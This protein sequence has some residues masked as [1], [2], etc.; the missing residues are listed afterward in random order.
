MQ[1]IT[2]TAALLKQQYVSQDALLGLLAAEQSRVQTEAST[3]LGRSTDELVKDTVL[4][5]GDKLRE[6]HFVAEA[7]LTT[8]VINN[9]ADFLVSQHVITAVNEAR[10]R[11]VIALVTAIVL[12][13]VYKLWEKHRPS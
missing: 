13:S 2:S 9:V 1:D 4:Y 12:D 5:I 10:D 8:Y 11:F 3:T 6:H 7:L